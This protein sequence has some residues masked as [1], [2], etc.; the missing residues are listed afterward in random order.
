MRTVLRSAAHLLR[1]AANAVVALCAVVFLSAA[2]ALGVIVSQFDGTGAVPAECAVVFGAAVVGMDRPGPAMT[3]RIATAAELYRQGL[4]DRLFLTGG[5]G[6]NGLGESEAEVM[7]REAV[8]QNVRAEDIVLE[9]LS[10]STLENLRFTRNL[11]SDCS[12]VIGISDAFHLARI[13]LLA[14]QIGWNSLQTYPT[15]GRPPAYLE[16]RSIIRE[17]LG[18]VYYG[19]RIHAF[20]YIEA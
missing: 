9:E 7:R 10:R 11:T 12:S 3:R 1:L 19:Y 16:D 17:M 6:G 13:K 20:F 18:Y 4:V 5:R 2:S 15:R 14:S 8:A